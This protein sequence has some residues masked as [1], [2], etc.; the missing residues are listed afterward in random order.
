MNEVEWQGGADVGAMLDHLDGK[1]SDRKLR[2]FACACVRRH[3]ARLRY[4]APRNAVA[5]AERLA[6]GEASEPE[7]EQ[8]RQSAEELAGNAPEY[9]QPVYQAAAATLAESALEAA[10][11]ASEMCRRQAVRESAYEVAPWENEQSV[12]A[13]AAAAELR[14]QADLLREVFGNP[15][16]PVVIEEDWLRAGGD[17]VRN[18]ARVIDEEHRMEE[19][20][21]LADALLDAGCGDA[22]LLEHLHAPVGHV[23]G[24]WA[25]DALLRRE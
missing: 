10:R 14:R 21:Y 8:M 11:G 3:W 19:L 18:M 4:T 22:V 7:V 9:E 6:E 5:L 1:V 20:P 15:F 2:L 24:C 25:L 13:A 16:R 23:L 12:N 17:V